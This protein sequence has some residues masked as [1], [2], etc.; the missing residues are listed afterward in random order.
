MNYYMITIIILIIAFWISFF[1][2][3]R[4][5]KKLI[6]AGF[7]WKGE[8]ERLNEELK[9]IQNQYRQVAKILEALRTIKK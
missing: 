7:Y 4:L 1:T 3:K 6:D 8:A 9:T 5:I 2:N